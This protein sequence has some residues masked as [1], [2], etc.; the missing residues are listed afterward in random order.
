MDQPRPIQPDPIR[1]DPIRPDPARWR[2][3]GVLLV[4]DTRAC[5]PRGVVATVA[6]A[7][8]GGVRWVQLRAKTE[9][10]GEVLELLGEVA[11]L[12]RDR[13]RLVVDDRV[14]VLL[15]ARARGL[16]VDGVHVGRRDL[17]V[18]LVRRL[19][20]PD[21]LVGLTT[22]TPALAARAGDLPPGTVD[23]LGVGA[24][25]ASTT[26]ADHPPVTGATGLAAVVAAA[27]RLP[28]VAIGG[29]VAG[30]LAAVRGTGA[31][32]AAVVAAVCADPDPRRA[33]AALVTAW[34]T[35]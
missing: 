27:G 20:G 21:A 4:A 35:P 11:E 30:D 24:F 16:A 23:Y 2:P 14:D 25:R 7:L 5:R 8:D 29:V 19:V 28:C 34:G 18:D 22:P 31:A 26:K 6:A 3:G 9:P 15:A 13:A 1:P 32:G 12:C 33:A 10:D 17:P